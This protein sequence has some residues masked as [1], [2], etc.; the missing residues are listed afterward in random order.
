VGSSSP[1]SHWRSW[2]APCLETDP[3]PA[4]GGATGTRAPSPLPCQAW[5]PGPRWPRAAC[6]LGAIIVARAGGDDDSDGTV[7]AAAES[8]KALKGRRTL[9]EPIQAVVAACVH[10]ATPNTR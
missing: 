9:H 5:L 2:R 10:A 7:T 8:V 6:V 4:L 1:A 3:S